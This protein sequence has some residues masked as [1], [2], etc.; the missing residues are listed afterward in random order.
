MTL[1]W[2]TNS[3]SYW[4]PRSVLNVVNAEEPAAI[5]WELTLSQARRQAL[6]MRFLIQFSQ[7]SRRHYYYSHFADGETEAQ[8]GEDLPKVTQPGNGRD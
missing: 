7:Q 3:K 4:V 5:R 1:E 2:K 8:R 6:S